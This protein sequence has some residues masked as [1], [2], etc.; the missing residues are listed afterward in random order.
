[1]KRRDFLT[2][3]AV[4]G[5]SSVGVSLSSQAIAKSA[6]NINNKAKNIKKAKVVVVGGGFAGAT[7]AKYLRLLSNNTI[8]VTLIEPRPHFIS[9]PMSNRIL[10]GDI[11]LEDI[12]LSYATLAKKYGIKI[13]ASTV[14][15]INSLNNT[16]S[17]GSVKCANGEKIAYDKLVVA[18]G[19]DFL[20]NKIAGYDENKHIHAWK[21][22]SQT[23]DLRKQLVAMPDGGTYVI[24]IPLA[25]YRCPPGPYERACL[26]ASYFKQYK[27]RS[28]VLILDA[29]PDVVSKPALF[30]KVW[31]EQYDGMVEYHSN[32]K[33]TE[34]KGNTVLNEVEDKFSGDVLNIIPPMQAGLIATK[35][36]LGTVWCDIDYATFESTKIPNIYV[37]GDASTSAPK[38]PKSGHIANQQGKYCAYAIVQKLSDAKIEA[39][40]Y[41][42]TCY[43]FGNSKEAGHVAAVYKYSSD[44]KNMVVVDGSSAVSPNV[45]LLEGEYAKSWAKGIWLD[46]LG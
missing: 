45:S 36:G 32:F 7:T 44:I 4:L 19:V 22:G 8:D 10:S 27:P 38:M 1:M 35:N 14:T 2:A 41:N 6:T 30:K 33:V 31:K 24:S 3:C 12:T 29:N 40:I 11:N 21:A 43:S 25:P 15:E 23:V 5:T 13:V 20:F 42:N 16:Q 17:G 46:T 9:C 37:I 18:P 39:P 34:I 28:K 26:V